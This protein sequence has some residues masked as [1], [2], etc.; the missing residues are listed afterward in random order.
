MMEVPS[1]CCLFDGFY[2]DANGL[3]WPIWQE[4]PSPATTHAILQPTEG[5]TW[6]LVEVEC[7]LDTNQ[8]Y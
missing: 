2:K 8:C 1:N 7:D 4:E 6:Y 3:G 5:R